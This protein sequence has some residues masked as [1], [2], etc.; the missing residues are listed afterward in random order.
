MIVLP[1]PILLAMTLGFLAL[2]MALGQRPAPLLAGLLTLL[3]VQALINALALHYGVGAARFMQPITAMCVPALAWLAWR[4]DALGHRLGWRD[5]VHGIGPVI[6]AALRL[7]NSLLLEMLV[8]LAYAGYA[9][10]LA[11]SLQR[12]GPD[13]PRAK[14][15]QG[16]GTRLI[17]AGIAGALACRPQV[18]WRLPFSWRWAKWPLCR[19]LWIL[20]QLQ[21]FW[22]WACWRSWRSA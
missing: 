6:A 9:G 18:M 17:W 8:P 10:A 15:G 19:A 7:E 2:R 3:A 1:L 13:L 12:T 21:G 11:L 22:A 5:V 20:P 16:D 14:M 4:A